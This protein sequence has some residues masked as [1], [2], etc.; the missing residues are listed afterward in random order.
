M[1]AL[2]GTWTPDRPHVAAPEGS[3]ARRFETL[4]SLFAAAALTAVAASILIAQATDGT[5]HAAASTRSAAGASYA[6]HGGET[7]FAG[8]SGVPYTYPSDVTIKKTGTHDFTVRNVEWEGKPFVNPI[9][10]GARI[11][12]W[13][14]E[15]RTGAMLDFTH[16]KT[17]ANPDQEAAFTGT[18]NGAPAPE[19]AAIRSIFKKLEASHGH[20]M[21]TLNGLL[22][23][24]SFV[25]RLH[26]Y[27]GVG[28]GVS[29]P[30]SEVQFANNDK[31]TYEYQTA[32]LVGQALFGI[33][34]RTARVSYFFEYKYTFA[35]YTMPL[36]ERDGSILFFDLW[37]QF[38][39]W[40][41]GEE[42]PGGRLTTDLA[43]HQVIG[44]IGIRTA[45]AVAA[46]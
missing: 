18:L 41:S 43:S 21:L 20:N 17:I 45:P 26:P 6:P 33:E 14:G 24:P 16:S 23:L 44:G 2:T 25:P 28:A 15:G 34:L 38:R 11:V 31:R 35:P 5:T 12:R 4:S 27:V 19:R 37:R 29:L 22:R 32:G 36:S 9:Y 42:P 7:M 10:Y 46:P 13:F 8:Y 1:R 30:H 3:R 39:D 40:L